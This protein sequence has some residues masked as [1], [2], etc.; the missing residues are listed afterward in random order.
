MRNLRN[1]FA[2]LALCWLTGCGTLA[3]GGYYQGDKVLY[4]ADVLISTSYDVVHTF[5][6]WEYTHRDTLAGTPEIRQTADKLRRE[7]PVWTRSAIACRDAYQAHPA[8][9]TKSALASALQVLREAMVQ[10][11]KYLSTSS[12]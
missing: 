7:F 8:S 5:V 12:L 11:S 1:L 3:P 4:D 9:D 2:L 10:A 6:S